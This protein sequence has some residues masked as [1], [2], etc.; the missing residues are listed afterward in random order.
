MNKYTKQAEKDKMRYQEEMKT[1]V[2]APDPTGGGKK[3]RK[4]VR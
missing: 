2:P 4:K 3:K 1:Y